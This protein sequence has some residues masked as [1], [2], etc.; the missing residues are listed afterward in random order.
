[1][2]KRPY[3]NWDNL[4]SALTSITE[5]SAERDGVSTASYGGSNAMTF[6]FSH[7]LSLF[8]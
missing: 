8:L 5:N 3:S 7:H 1:M 6:G 2:V 4:V